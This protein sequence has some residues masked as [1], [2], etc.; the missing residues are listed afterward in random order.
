MFSIYH[1]IWTAVFE[2]ILIHVKFALGIPNLS[3]WKT[4]LIHLL[5]INIEM[6]SVIRRCATENILSK[7]LNILKIALSNNIYEGIFGKTSPANWM[8][9]L[10]M[11]IL[12]YYFMFYIALRCQS[13]SCFCFLFLF[14]SC[15]VFLDLPVDSQ[16]QLLEQLHYGRFSHTHCDKS[17][18]P[19][20][21][22][23]V[24]VFTISPSSV[25]FSPSHFYVGTQ[26]HWAGRCA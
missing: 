24:R 4:C 9:E 20:P 1:Y 10:K 11:Q 14:A 12:W 16:E 22:S 17:S 2:S 23:P 21:H 8:V 15:E 3:Y 13:F 7:Q 18:I 26:L 25:V 19:S 6:W 5:L